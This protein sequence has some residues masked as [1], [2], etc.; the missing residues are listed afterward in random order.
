MKAVRL[1]LKIAG[2]LFLLFVAVGVIAVATSNGKKHKATIATDGSAATTV[3]VALPFAASELE[4]KLR[5]KVAGGDLFKRGSLHVRTWDEHQILMTF[6][7]DPGTIEPDL[8]EVSAMGLGKLTIDEL[9]AAGFNPREHWTMIFVWVEQPAGPSVT[10]GARVRVFGDAKYDF[11][12]DR[13]TF[14]MEK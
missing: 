8:P 11:S 1:A 10:G 7:F 6:T 4:P 3:V 12:E 14:E 13:L 9:I 2:V 5:A